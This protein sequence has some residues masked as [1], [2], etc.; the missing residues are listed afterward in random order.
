M[1]RVLKGNVYLHDINND[2]AINEACRDPFG[3]RPPV[4][5]TIA[6]YRGLPGSSLV[7]IVD[8]APL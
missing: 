4:R 7:E 6:R 8:S 5:T 1:D 2:A 3:S